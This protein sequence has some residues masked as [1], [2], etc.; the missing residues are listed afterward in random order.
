MLTMFESGELNANR[1]AG[2]VIG[3]SG[4]EGVSITGVLSITVCFSEPQAL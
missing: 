4:V 1:P 3:S 2:K